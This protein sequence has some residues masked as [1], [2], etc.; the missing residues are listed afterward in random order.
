MAVGA[1]VALGALKIGAHAAGIEVLEL[2]SLFSSVIGGAVFVFGLILAGTLADFK[3][4][5]RIPSEIASLCG[6]IVEDGRYC[7]QQYPGFD[8]KKLLVAVR[9][10][11][12]AVRADLGDTESRTALAA[13]GGLTPS[14]L[15]MERT[16]L[17]ANH[18]VRLKGEQASLRRTVMRVYYIQR[19]DFLPSAYNFVRSLVVLIIALLVF[20]AI[21]PVLLGAT[22]IAFITYLFVYILRLLRTLD[23]PFRVTERTNDDASLFLLREMESS[24][25]G[26]I[27]HA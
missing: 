16:G 14:L 1:F 20:T 27:A 3:E 9:E 22:L 10:F 26:E 2:N 6:S 25:D 21:E 12:A 19:I 11:L 7:K 5:E 15:E 17:P 18:V 13:I 8:L 24:L 23:T 4:S